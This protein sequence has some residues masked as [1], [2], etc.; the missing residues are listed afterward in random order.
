VLVA[1]TFRSEQG[2]QLAATYQV[3]N[4]VAQQS[5]GRP[6]SGGTP[7]VFVNLIEPGTLYG[8]R[9]NVFD[10]RIAKVVRVG[11]TRTNVGL[12]LY[13]VSNSDA[14]L[15]YNNSFTP[16]GRWLAPTSILSPRFVKF[17]A[18]IEF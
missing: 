7:F 13:N 4:S 15:S 6:L 12:D 10:L 18:H 3:P 17:S 14:I 1:G 11:R 2:N 16:G 8:E 9:V 5:L